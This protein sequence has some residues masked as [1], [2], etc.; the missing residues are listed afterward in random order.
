M[1]SNI[2][3]ISNWIPAISTTSLLAL[4]IWFFRSLI[5]T[6]LTKSIEN[7]FNTKLENLRSELRAKEAQIDALRSGAM[8]GLMSRQS[9]L[10]ER[11]IEAIEQVWEAVT[12]LGKSQGHFCDYGTSKV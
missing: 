1:D 7:E 6:W 3:D 8:S 5:S 2:L 9:K 11:Q 4:A 12:E 10:Y